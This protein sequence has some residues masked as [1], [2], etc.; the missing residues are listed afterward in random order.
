MKLPSQFSIVNFQ[1]FVS[2]PTAYRT[3]LRLT[4]AGTP[5]ALGITDASV[6]A[7]LSKSRSETILNAQIVSLDGQAATLHVGQRYP[8][9]TNSY[10]AA[11]GI[12]GQ[13]SAPAPA[14]NF[15]DLGLVLKIT[16]WIHEGH[17]IT[18]DL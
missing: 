1:G 17:E 15:E 9:V 18:L 7:T 5:F 14:V 8:I 16:P 4:G 2:L 3:L 13:F 11:P 6:F 12:A 10:G